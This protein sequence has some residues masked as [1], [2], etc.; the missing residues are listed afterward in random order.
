MH[1]KSRYIL[2]FFGALLVARCRFGMV[3]YGLTVV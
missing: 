3:L 1:P 2:V